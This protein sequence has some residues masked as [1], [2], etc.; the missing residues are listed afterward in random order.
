MLW[1]SSLSKILSAISAINSPFDGLSCSLK[2]FA[3]KSVLRAI[4]R[5][6]L[7]Q[8]SR[9]WRIARSTLVEVVLCCSAMC[10]YSWVVILLIKMHGV[11]TAILIADFKNS[12][13]VRCLRS[14]RTIN[15]SSIRQ[16]MG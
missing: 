6:L 5:L 2:T 12:V 3:L 11:S 15:T 4:K 16:S 7:K 8:V 14:P 10:G 1:S 9:Q 13:P